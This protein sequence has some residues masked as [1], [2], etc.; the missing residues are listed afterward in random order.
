MPIWD[1]VASLP[2][3]G[4]RPGARR[5]WRNVCNVYL[6][7]GSG[8]MRLEREHRPVECPAMNKCTRSFVVF[9]VLVCPLCLYAADAR[10]REVGYDE[11]QVVR[12]EG[13]IGFQTMIEFGATESIENVGLGDASRWIVV[14]NKRAN[15]LFVKPSYAT[16]HS[17]M[18]VSTS[19]HRYS[20]ELVAKP[21]E[22]CSRGMV[23]Y[24]LRFRY[25]AAAAVTEPAVEKPLPAL[26]DPLPAPARRNSD[27]TYDGARE[28]V[29]RRVFDDGQSTWFRW[30]KGA[31]TPAVY[32][33]GT[34]KSETLVNFTSHGDYL[35]ADQVAPAFVLRL[36][37]AVAT[38]YNDAY[39]TPTLDAGSPRPRVSPGKAARRGLFSWLRHK[40][41]DP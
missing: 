19:R 2:V 40:R 22:K 38:L 6:G 11:N 37:N 36:G 15:L 30:D 32:A 1:C 3:A 4:T 31:A 27:Y 17:N 14:P 13:C 23:V 21:S 24:D 18:T 33:V 5:G 34:D 7:W 10:I 12:L 29:P 35:V 8:G 25:P 20:F 41:A 9:A 16:S 28:Q 26:V 39:Q